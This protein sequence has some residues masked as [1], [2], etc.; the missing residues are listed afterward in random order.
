[1]PQLIKTEGKKVLFG[2]QGV[3]VWQFIISKSK[4]EGKQAMITET[5]S[6]RHRRPH[7]A[8]QDRPPQDRLGPKT[9]SDP[10]P[11]AP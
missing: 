2:G 6:L 1:M 9:D 10:R 8:T 3:L 5:E 4:Q 7:Q 11:T